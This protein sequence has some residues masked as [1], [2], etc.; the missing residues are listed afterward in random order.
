MATMEGR[1][2]NRQ[3]EGNEKKGKKLGER[4]GMKKINRFGLFFTK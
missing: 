2:G 3:I 1:R 4:E